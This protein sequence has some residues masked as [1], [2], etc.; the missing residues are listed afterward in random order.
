MKLRVATL[1]RTNKNKSEKQ[2]LRFA[3]NDKKWKDD[4]SGGVDGVRRPW[5]GSGEVGDFG[6]DV[7]EVD[8]AEAAFGGEG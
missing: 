7:F 6:W 3:Q 4:K 8:A 1:G 2:I 5:A